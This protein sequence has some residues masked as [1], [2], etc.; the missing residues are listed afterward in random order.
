MS[1]EA[2]P[3]PADD[4]APRSG[5][6]PLP[7][8]EDLPISDEGYDQQSV[9]AAF[10]AFYRHAAQL[11]SSLRTL[12]AVDSFHRQA[13][14]LRADIRTLRTAGWSQ[15]SWSATPA[16]GY[17]TKPAR[18]GVSPAVWRIGAEAA[19]IIAVA[20][21][22]GVAKLDWWVIVLVLAAAWLIVGL[23]EWLASREVTA[24][25]VAPRAP[26]HPVVEAESGAPAEDQEASGWA[27]YEEPQEPSD[28][29]T[30]IGAP[31]SADTEDQ[32]E[33]VEPVPEEEAVAEAEPEPEPVPATPS[34]DVVPTP[35][36][37]AG[38]EEAE[39]PRRRWFARK[40][41]EDQASEHV[42]IAEPPRH[43][44]VL[45][46]DELEV[47]EA[48]PDADQREAIDPWEQ[49]FDDAEPPPEALAA[50]PDEQT[51]ENAP[52]LAGE[53]EPPARR[54]FRRR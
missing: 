13:A 42:E 14:A 36:E 52:A 40:D 28:A 5:R 51:D 6:D 41:D 23:V 7:R 54:R 8:V 21:A 46:A 15:Q 49:G 39:R 43:V 12:E 22:L 19:F 37:P 38:G 31:P 25:P 47:V 34:D 35:D 17:G 50:E 29:M 10:D 11:D 53:L 3:T 27:A 26:V 1:Q 18:E 33:P 30:M 32:V 24:V 20:V 9:R 16:Y 44:R 4:A 2:W 45:Q 48:P